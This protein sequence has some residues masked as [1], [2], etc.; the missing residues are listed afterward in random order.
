[1]YIWHEGIASK[2][3]Q[4]IASCLIY[5]C[6][7]FLPKECKQLDLYSDSCGGQNRNI[8]TSVMLSHFLEKSQHLQTVIQHLQ[9]IIQHFYVPG[10]SN[11]VC[12]RKFAIIEKK[13][14][15]QRSLYRVSGQI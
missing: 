11:N 6:T 10:H 8:K 4:E 14:K 3:P 7:H 5:H 15:E 1:M 13:E 9:T 12:D 2:G